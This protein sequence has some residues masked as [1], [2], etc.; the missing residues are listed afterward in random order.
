MRAVA[1][2][3]VAGLLSS[4]CAFV[5]GG[6]GYKL[7]AYFP[8][9]VSLYK[10][11]NVR[12][13]GLPAGRVTRIDVVGATV[14]VTM[15][16]DKDIKLPKD[17]NAA[18]VPQSLIGERYVQLFPAWVEG[19]PTEPAGSV[20][21]LERT[22]IPVEPD[23]ALAALKKFLDSLDPKA[24]GQLVHNLA[25]DLRGN[26]QNLND[27]IAGLANLSNTLADKDQEIAGIV[28]HFDGF[29][30]TLRTREAQLGKVMDQFAV[31][32]KLLADERQQ[33][34]GLLHNLA[35]ISE[36][37][38][39]LVSKHSAALDHDLTVLTH[40]L[41]AVNANL[42]SVKLLLSSGP[43][44]VAGADLTG[45]TS[46]LAAAYDP[47]YHHL[48]LRNVSSPTAAQ[49]FNA[50]GIPV[51]QV[52]LPADV[53]CSVPAPPGGAGAA[54]ASGPA[55]ST[56]AGAATLP[57]VTVPPVTVPPVTTPTAPAADTGVSPTAPTTSSTTTPLLTVP[58]VPSTRLSS[59]T[60]AAS[61]TDTVL[62]LMSMP[63]SSTDSFSVPSSAG[64]GAIDQLP[65]WTHHRSGWFR[66]VVAAVARAL[67]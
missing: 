33:I 50:L 14:K 2:A 42:D 8:R 67:P 30:A 5:G 28:D 31:T 63:A 62:R 41:E 27:A 39:D 19:Q 60:A 13:L 23:E 18:L 66:Q 1:V 12:V 22:S 35:T 4:S 24:T 34:E 59:S 64:A 51:N 29:T 17:V 56:G 7:T 55:A 46:G 48:D 54:G 26:G 20:I 10:Q 65:T 15:S 36:T 32:T 6:K 57:A 38:L 3:L 43:T 44:L 47:K 9:A 21:P 53:S 45:T 58:T 16:I 25:D 61:P 49:L 37:G 52:C 40:T 11:S